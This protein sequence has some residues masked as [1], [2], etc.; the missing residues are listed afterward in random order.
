MYT[1]F[2]FLYTVA[3]HIYDHVIQDDIDDQLCHDH[4]FLLLFVIDV[5][6]DESVRFATNLT[7]SSMFSSQKDI[8]NVVFFGDSVSSQLAQGLVCDLLRAGKEW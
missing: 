6:A 2:V 5:A 3:V 1:R 8:T 4:S 7:S